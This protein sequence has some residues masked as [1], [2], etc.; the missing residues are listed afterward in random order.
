VILSSLSATKE[1]KSVCRP[2]KVDEVLHLINVI[3]DKVFVWIQS[4]LGIKNN[5][6]AD[7]LAQNA[8]RDNISV[9]IGLEILENNKIVNSYIIDKW[10]VL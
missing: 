9:N 6:K 1:E 7:H 2:K 5:E 10:T 3:P 8:T 4:H